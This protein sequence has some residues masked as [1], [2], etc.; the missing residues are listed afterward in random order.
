MTCGK[1][2][3]KNKKIRQA[4]RKLLAV[5]RAWGLVFLAL[6]TGFSAG[7]N[8]CA[9]HS[10]DSPMKNPRIQSGSKPVKL[11][12]QV[13]GDVGITPLRLE[14]V[15]VRLPSVVRPAQPRAGG[16]NPGRVA[17]GIW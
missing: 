12:N 4:T 2:H 1:L 17:A 15:W 11:K 9:S 16:R 5:P 7:S 13:E 8:P 3:L 10:V 6:A 14:G